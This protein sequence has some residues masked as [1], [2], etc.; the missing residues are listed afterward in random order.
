MKRGR[1]SERLLQGGFRRVSTCSVSAGTRNNIRSVV[2]FRFLLA[3]TLKTIILCQNTARL[4]RRRR[5]TKENSGDRRWL[6]WA[7]GPFGDAEQSAAF[8]RSLVR[9]RAVQ[10]RTTLLRERHGAWT[11]VSF[12]I[13]MRFFFNF[14]F[15]KVFISVEIVQLNNCIF[16]NNQHF[17]AV[18]TF[19]FTKVT[20][21]R[22]IFKHIQKL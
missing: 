8:G 7:S 14:T 19:F 18:Y 4:N 21:F 1:F 12:S 17:S 13:S 6:R 20:C 2:I 3:H 5:S 9:C 16:F 11:I 22:Q 10:W 15:A